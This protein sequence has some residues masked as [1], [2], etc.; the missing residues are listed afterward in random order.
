MVNWHLLGTVWHPL[1]GAGIYIYIYIISECTTDY[2]FPSSSLSTSTIVAKKLAPTNYSLQ[3]IAKNHHPN[4][5]LH[6]SSRFLLLRFSGKLFRRIF[7]RAQGNAVPPAFG[8]ITLV[9]FVKPSE[10]AVIG[11][12]VQKLVGPNKKDWTYEPRLNLVFK[13]TPEFNIFVHVYTYIYIY[14]K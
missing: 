4:S 12:D 6:A 8:G 11:G 3:K 10:A 9:D 2:T 1:E 14:L 13:K 5:E 7:H